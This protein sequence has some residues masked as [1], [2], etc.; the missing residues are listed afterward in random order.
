MAT[1]TAGGLDRYFELIRE[2]PLRPIRPEAE[3]DLAI[4]VIDVLTDRARLTTG[5]TDYLLV[6]STLVEQYEAEHHPLPDITGVDALRFFLREGGLTQ[7]QLSAET[8]I[9]KSSLSEILEGK[10]GFSR[11][12]RDSRKVGRPIQGRPVDFCLIVDR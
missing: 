1:T 7:T 3:L 4:A 11:S 12:V 9:P 8:G 2:L 10:R 6:L 5:E